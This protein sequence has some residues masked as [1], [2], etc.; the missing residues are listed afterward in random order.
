MK[1]TN[2]N[3]FRDPGSIANEPGHQ[4]LAYET[5]HAPHF[6]KHMLTWVIFYISTFGKEREI[7]L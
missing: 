4:I 6:V 1:V 5:Q 3:E 7:F 2:T